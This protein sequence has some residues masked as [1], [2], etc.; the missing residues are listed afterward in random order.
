MGPGVKQNPDT[1]Q[2]S[3][4]LRYS[5]WSR[6]V[7]N[8]WQKC[9][10]SLPAFHANS[11]AVSTACMSSR[12]SF[13]VAEAADVFLWGVSVPIVTLHTTKSRASSQVPQEITSKGWEDV[14][15]AGRPPLLT[16][17][18]AALPLLLFFYSSHS[19]CW[20]FH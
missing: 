6:D 5:T 9:E 20:N 17:I 11:S 12:T 4:S 18:P 13:Q 16:P 8:T 19:F 14:C 7:I 1:S 15:T 3:A 10:V 2:V